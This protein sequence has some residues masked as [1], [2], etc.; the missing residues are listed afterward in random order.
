M[1]LSQNTPGHADSP[2]R[3]TGYC[4]INDPCVGAS[5]G[6]ALACDIRIA[7]DNANFVVGFNGIGLVPN[8]AVSLLLPALV[9]LGHTTELTFTNRPVPAGEALEWGMVPSGLPKGSDGGS[10]QTSHTTGGWALPHFWP[11]ETR[12]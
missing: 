3:E 10:K 12:F 1:K 11:D 2:D 7:S 8:S 5:L 9:C 6:I 4:S